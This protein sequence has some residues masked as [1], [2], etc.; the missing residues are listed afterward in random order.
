MLA[1]TPGGR[2][3]CE[4]GLGTTEPIGVDGAELAGNE[5]LGIDVTVEVV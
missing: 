3:K 2:V 1:I 4:T 5:E